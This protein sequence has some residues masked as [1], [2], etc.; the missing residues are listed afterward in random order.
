MSRIHNTAL[1][2]FQVTSFK[3]I[4]FIVIC[5]RYTVYIGFQML[6]IAFLSHLGSRVRICERLRI[7]AIDSKES[8]PPANVAWRT[9][10]FNRVVVRARQAG[11]R[12]LGSLKGLK[13]RAQKDD[14]YERWGSGGGWGG[15]G[16]LKNL[17][18][19]TTFRPVAFNRSVHVQDTEDAFCILSRVK[20]KNVTFPKIS[21][22][23]KNLVLRGKVVV[24]KKLAR[25]Q[26]L[27]RHDLG[28]E[29]FVSKVLYV[30]PSP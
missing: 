6:M 12:F 28:R 19:K 14:S 29:A 15:A 26:N 22:S 21:W 20:V 30:L 18:W 7:P 10:T 13:I 17:Q 23:V 5:R 2:P 3:E 25:E 4:T 9:V 24:E 16:L 1:Q 27:S 8:I 11:N